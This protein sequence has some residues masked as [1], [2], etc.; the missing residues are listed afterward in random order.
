[1]TLQIKVNSQ[2]IDSWNENGFLFIKG[3]KIFDSETRK[4]IISEVDDMDNWVDQVGKS[5]F[6]YEENMDP[7]RAKVL[8][9][10]EYFLDYSRY[11]SSIFRGEDFVNFISSLCGQPLVLYKEKVNYKYPNTSGFEPHQ[12][13]QAGWG[14]HGH[15]FH[16]SVGVSIDPSTKKN[17]ALELVRKQHKKG[18]IGEMFKPISQD[19][20]DSLQWEMFETDPL[21]IIIFDS[22][23]PHR[24]S[25]NFSDARRRM[26][27]LTYNYLSEGDAREIYFKDK[28]KSFPP[29]IE[30][31]KNTDYSYKI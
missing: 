28:R 12:D 7:S 24:S 6:Y 11:L 25:K 13:A 1:M 18:L 15:T 22:Y 5:F 8:N 9:R 16:L 31:D 29:D 3:N 23:T 17:G 10:I 19:V 26:L 20:V 30:R 4:R 14:A 2:D 21:D 27:F